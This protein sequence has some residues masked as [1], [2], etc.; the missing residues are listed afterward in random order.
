MSASYPV[1]PAKKT[2]T[3]SYRIR[4]DLKSALADEARRLSI[5]PNAL[6]SQIFDRH[7][8]WGRYVEQLKFIPVSKDF[9]RLIFDSIP[10]KEAE[11]IGKLLGESAARE[12]ILFLYSRINP[13]T[14]LSF[15]DLWASHFDAWDHQYERGKH[16][17]TVKHDINLNYSRFT[18]EY[19]SAILD[20]TLE[21]RVQFETMSPNSLTFVFENLPSKP[22]DDWPRNNTSDKS[23]DSVWTGNNRNGTRMNHK[24]EE[25]VLKH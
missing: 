19:L 10:Q 9:L 16:I 2:E 20:N 17:F 6:V 12:E 1:G 18:K 8:S 24:P 3:V 23:R 15:I 11:K 25:A 7:I 13:E 5:N 21:T 4:S 22:G 14:I